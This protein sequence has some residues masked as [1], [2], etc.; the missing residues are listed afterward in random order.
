[1]A[2]P[3]PALAPVKT[4]YLALTDLPLLAGSLQKERKVVCM[5]GSHSSRAVAEKVLQKS[6]GELSMI[7]WRLRGETKGMKHQDGVY[8]GALCYEADK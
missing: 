7:G 2:G 5:W 4:S 1:M 8:P 6:Q 3:I